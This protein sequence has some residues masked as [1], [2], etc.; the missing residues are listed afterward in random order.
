MKKFG[1]IIS[2]EQVRDILPERVDI[3]EQTG[4]WNIKRGKDNY[5]YGIMRFD[6]KMAKVHRISYWA[7][8]DNNFKVLDNVKEFICHSCDNP[9]CVNPEHLFAGD[10]S[11]NNVDY[12][13]KKL[14]KV[15]PLKVRQENRRRNKEMNERRRR[16]NVGT[17]ITKH[18]RKELDKF[19]IEIELLCQE[20]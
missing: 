11:D 14:G 3:D 4:C 6:G 12:Y 1:K 16:M 18:L 10:V 5:G 7:Y 20:N 2:P 8:K 9:S 15:R 13:I 17:E 19:N